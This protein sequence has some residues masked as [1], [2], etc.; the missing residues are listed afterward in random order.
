MY[1][2]LKKLIHIKLF[3]NK[4]TA[5]L[6]ESKSSKFIKNEFQFLVK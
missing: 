2:N 6:R 3:Y 4:K 1:N 5:L